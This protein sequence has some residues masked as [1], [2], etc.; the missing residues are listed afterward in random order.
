[1][2]HCMLVFSIKRGLNF[3]LIVGEEGDVSSWRIFTISDE[4]S[5]LAYVDLVE[6]Y[7]YNCMLN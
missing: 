4:I 1:M 7:V 5:P 3:N 2:I 6:N